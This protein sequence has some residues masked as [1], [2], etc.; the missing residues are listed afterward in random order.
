MF[1]LNMKDKNDLQIT[2]LMIM[3]E[4]NYFSEVVEYVRDFESSNYDND[5]DKDEFQFHKEREKMVEQT[6]KEQCIKQK[7]FKLVRVIYLNHDMSMKTKD[8]LLPASDE[9]FL[10]LAFILSMPLED[11]IEM[12]CINFMIDKV[13]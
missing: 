3:D 6:L 1:V 9:F 12:D 2:I 11:A 8:F 5:I 7:D 13:S 4:N 10:Y